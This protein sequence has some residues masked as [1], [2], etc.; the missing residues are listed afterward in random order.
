MPRRVGSIMKIES[1]S[2]HGPMP[3][4]GEGLF[5]E[6]IYSATL[7]WMGFRKLLMG[8]TLFQI[9]TCRLRGDD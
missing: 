1:D 2:L 9:D 6:K 3:D 8:T 4:M 5:K 7:F